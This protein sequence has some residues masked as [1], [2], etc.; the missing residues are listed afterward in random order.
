ME[1]RDLLRKNWNVQLQH[2][3]REGNMCV[4]HLAKKEATQNQ[5]LVIHHDTPHD[6]HIQLLADAMGVE[7][8]RE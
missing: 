3:L 6:I 5:P 7:T 8:L 2:I 1:I 4:D